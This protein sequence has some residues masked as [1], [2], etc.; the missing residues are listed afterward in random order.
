[1]SSDGLNIS[2]P[3]NPLKLLPEELN[4]FVTWFLVAFCWRLEA[5][6]RLP[7]RIEVQATGAASLNLHLDANE[8]RLW[9]IMRLISHPGARFAHIEYRATRL[10]NTKPMLS[11]V[12]LENQPPSTT[13]LF[14]TPR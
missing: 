2:G 5:R 4:S 14:S 6:V 8:R 11:T 3:L 9:P 12:T 7:A 13:T 10:L 1:M